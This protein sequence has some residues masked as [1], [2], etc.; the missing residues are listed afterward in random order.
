[1]GTKNSFSLDAK[2][3][4]CTNLTKIVLF[5]EVH[6]PKQTSARTT[7]PAVS[8]EGKSLGRTR[9]PEESKTPGWTARRRL[10]DEKSEALK[11]GTAAAG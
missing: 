7:V 4:G 1:M 6:A 5:E 3:N 2:W 8:I 9:L 11:P 10:A